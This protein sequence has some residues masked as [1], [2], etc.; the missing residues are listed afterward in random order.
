MR[1]LSNGSCSRARKEKGKKRKSNGLQ[2]FNDFVHVGQLAVIGLEWELHLNP[3]I[4]CRFCP[5][6]YSRR[7]QGKAD[8]VFMPYNYLIDPILRKSQEI[9]LNNA[10]VIFDEAH[11]L[12]ASCAEAT[13]FS[14][15]NLQIS[16]CLDELHKATD[17]IFE[18][19]ENSKSLTPNDVLILKGFGFVP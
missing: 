12:E 1:K 11:N 13:S 16:A 17:I 7:L 8:I 2:G 4:S 9:D 5:Y 6:Y 3:P 10:I 18:Q 14:L 15:T 19:S